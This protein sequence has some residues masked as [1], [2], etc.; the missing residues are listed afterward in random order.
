[1]PV[2]FQPKTI[3]I[4]Q[5]HSGT[6]VADAVTN[7]MFFIQSLLHELGFRSGVFARYVDPALADRVLSIEALDLAEND[8][9]FIHHSMGHDDLARLAN[10]KCRKV[11]V[12]H[13]ITPPEFFARDPQTQRYVLKGYAQLSELRAVVS[14]AITFSD[15][16][17][18]ELRKRDYRDVSVVPLLKDFGA[19][20]YLP[21]AK[22]PYYDDEAV[23]RLLFVGRVVPH[24]GHEELIRFIDRYRELGGVPV[25]LVLV[26]KFDGDPLYK[27]HL[28]DL[29]AR[30]HLHRFIQFVGRVG[31][32][33]LY[34][35]YRAA[36]VYLSLSAHEGFGVPLIEAMAFD[37]PVI[38][39]DRAAVGGTL[40]TAGI[41]IGD[42]E[43]ETI[44]HAIGRLF[45][46]GAYR[47]S[48]IRGQ[49]Q[50]LL[51][52]SREQIAGSL[53]RWLADAGAYEP[54]S[55]MDAHA[56]E[57]DRGGQADLPQY[58]VEGPYETSYSLA[59]V[60]RNLALALDRTAGAGG[61]LEPADGEEDYSTDIAAAARLPVEMQ[62]LAAPA[63]LTPAPI[64]TI[65]NTYPTRPNG[66]LG[67]LR[68]VH[69]AWEESSI[70]DH[71]AEL[72]NFH[73][74]GVLA[75]SAYAKNVIRN[76]GVRVP[77]AVIGHGLDHDG[78]A[79]A[80][81]GRDSRGP[82]SAAMP[83]TFLHIS[84]GLA[85]KGIEELISAYCM[86]FSAADPVLLVIKT[87]DNPGNRV[88]SWI[89]RLTGAHSPSIQVISEEITQTE[90][91]FLYR[92][93]DAIVLPTRGEGFNLPAAEGMARGIPVITTRHS[94]HLDFCTD[95]NCYLIDCSFEFS[96]SQLGVHNSY[97][98]RPAVDQL[99]TTM[100]DLVRSGRR[101]HPDCRDR[102]INAHKAVADFRWQHVAE[103]IDEFVK[104]LETR[105]VMDRRL[106]LGWIS[107]YNTRCGIAAYSS[108]LL[109]FFD[110]KT[111]EITIFADDQ[112]GVAADPPN[113]LRLWS[114]YDRRLDRVTDH[115]IAQNFDVAF[116]QHHSGLYD[117]HC[118]ADA[119]SRLTA[120]GIE[121]F[122]TLHQ[123]SDLIDDQRLV[124][125]RRMVD[126][127]SA[128]RRIFV[129]S[130][131][132]VGYLQQHGITDNVVLL[133]HG[134]VYMPSPDSSAVRSLIGLSE[135]TPTIGSFG[136]LVP[137]KG[138]TQLIHGFALLLR[139][140]PQAYLLLVNSDYP[141]PQSQEERQRCLSLIELLEIGHRVR[142][143]NEFVDNK[144]AL[145]LL[146]ACDAIVYPYQHSV[147]SASGAVRFGLAAGPPVV[148]TPHTVFGDLA[149][150]VHQLH[151]STAADIA[152]GVIDL[153]RDRTLNAAVR[154]RQR[155]W[156]RSN[157]WQFQA[158][159]MA[160]IVVGCFEER[161]QVHLERETAFAPRFEVSARSGGA[162]AVL[163]HQG[164]AE[165]DADPGLDEVE[166][167]P[168]APSERRPAWFRFFGAPQPASRRKPDNA[169]SNSS[170]KRIH[171]RLSKADRARD[172]RDWTSA[173]RYYREALD[174]NANDS[175]IWVQY[176]HTLKESGR[177][178]DAE[179]AYRQS[180][181]LAPDI[182]DTH[183]Q[184]G[185]VLKLQE[186]KVE[187]GQAY[188]DALLRDPGLGD[189]ETEL[190]ALGWTRGRIQFGL[191]QE[192]GQF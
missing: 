20:R 159:R 175:A 136:F 151:G 89:E 46:D 4:H 61:H 94:G 9:L 172:N 81:G 98:A 27:A 181:L 85:R 71:V 158:S 90:L 166:Q 180:L 140:Y 38:A 173:A 57:P 26:G 107:T 67:D 183:L 118:F 41:L 77:I 14:R 167:V 39:Y 147:E 102:S 10:L 190:V 148:T 178:R 104:Y 58:I 112:P 31:D 106:R 103:R 16:I 155:D 28:D 72:I 69:L 3:A 138:L 189:A 101:Q 43:P 44:A 149:G 35:W 130:L 113:M 109:E 121:T 152:T 75:P 29:I 66:M 6:E 95:E 48:L 80:I 177:L 32:R 168:A 92:L 73:L 182:A 18:T 153:L 122:V 157:S 150:I 22:T 163:P 141:T 52:F 174:E 13:G 120:A 188:F 21:H 170:S 192:F 24:K 114:K 34:G 15:H 40:G 1:M 59:I 60:N 96:D 42:R 23:L 87:F 30:H 123:I 12:Y 105:P 176:G 143:I 17:A 51:Q 70:P 116:F 78:A 25:R 19:I 126:T 36:N 133:P 100:K 45:D 7:S 135:F 56:V 93:A 111:F 125:H 146:S 83:F 74:D 179:S 161:Q 54:H 5:F 50:R 55:H 160:N 145:F 37:L 115:L 137:G 184:L 53:R 187:A 144:E 139:S 191:R 62:R 132:D 185:H 47:R 164:D 11:L 84:S 127:L 82:V 156:V 33:E 129:H 88:D 169:R 91:E 110:E 124:S 117:F 165:I 8:I 128:C 108:H 131:D 162:A 186:R 171:K 64:V 99:I 142:L 49:R 65:R 86:A 2:E 154:K 76:S 63:P 79:P 134:A 97:W 119:V 68:L